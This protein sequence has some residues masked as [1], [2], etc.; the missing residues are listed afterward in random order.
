MKFKPPALNNKATG[1]HTGRIN[2]SLQILILSVEQCN[3][4]VIQITG[5]HDIDI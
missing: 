3:S 1:Q 5:I 2:K 4:M